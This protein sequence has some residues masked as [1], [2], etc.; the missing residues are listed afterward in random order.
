MVEV[1]GAQGGFLLTHA[2]E[3]DRKTRIRHEVESALEVVKAAGAV[4]TDTSLFIKVDP[5]ASKE[6]HEF[7]K[8]GR[9]ET[10]NDYIVIHPGARYEYMKWSADG[11][12]EVADMLSDAFGFTTVL[13][14]TKQ[15]EA[16]CERVSSLMKTA[17]VN[18]AGRTGLPELTALIAAS[19]LF[20]GNSSG[21][22]HIAAALG[23]PVVGIFGNI[24][25][26]DCHLE[27]GPWTERK[28]IVSAHLNCDECR[29]DECEHLNC[30]AGITPSMVYD[31]AQRLLKE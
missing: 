9:T 19:R 25:P 2:V 10:L 1:V 13:V 22:M 6:A 5:E 18:A 15:E 30:M 16:L 26:L 8:A 27:W 17:V 31:V 3:D 21:P 28:A 23:V 12:A 7:L 11:F 29:P 24:H 4:Y 14:G 20:I